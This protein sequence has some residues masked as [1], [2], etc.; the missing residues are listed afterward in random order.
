MNLTCLRSCTLALLLGAMTN[1]T[2]AQNVIYPGETLPGTALLAETDGTYTLSNDLLSVSFVKDGTSLKFGGCQALNLLSGSELF[3]LN[4]GDGTVVPASAMTLKAVSTETLTANPDAVKGSEKFPGQAIVAEFE[5]NGLNVN[6]RAV[7]RDGSHY[8]RT[9]MEISPVSSNVNMKSIVAM[10]YDVKNVEGRPAPQVVGNTRGAI[11]ASDM[12]FAG[13]ETPMG[14]NS[15]LS[16]SSG[17]ESFTPTSWTPESFSWT[18]GNETPAAILELKTIAGNQ[19]LT[20]DNIVGTR[21]YLTFRQ[22][23][24]QTVTFQYASG[25]HRLNIVGVD[26]CDPQTGEVIAS[27]YHAGFTGGQK[28]DNVYTLNLPRA[29]SFIVRYFIETLS[30]TITSSGN[31]TYSGKIAIPEVVFGKDPAAEKPAAVRRVLS[32][33]E[34][35]V[36]EEGETETD[37]WTGSSWTKT[38]VE[39]VPARIKE[40][41][42]AQEN[43]RQMERKISFREPATLTVEF[44]YTSGNHRLDI[45]GVDLIDGDGNVVVNDY[46]NGYSGHN[47]ENNVYKFDVPFAGDFSIRYFA[48]NADNALSTNGNINLSYNKTYVIYLPV[49]EAQTI[50]GLWSRPVTLEAGKTWTVSAVAGL[51]APD[52]A[53]RSVAAY[54]D[55]ERAVAW[56]PFPIYNSWFELNINRKD[57]PTYNS[58]MKVSD[59]V[60]VVNQ[61]EKKLYQA[62]GANIGAFVWDDGW[63]EWGSWEFNKNFP[64]GFTEINEVATSMNTGIGT[65]L[66]PVGGYGTSG[67]SRR[68]YWNGKGGMQLSNP[69][70][71]DVFLNACSRMIRD[72][73]F[74]FFKFDGISGLFAAYGPDPNNEEGAEGIIDIEQRLREIKPDIFLNTT[75]GTW[76]SPFWYTVSDCTW[77][78]ENDYGKAGN[79]SIDREQWITYRD[80]LVYQNY[81]TG[82]PLCPIN[83]IM[84]HGLIL[85]S[86]ENP[87]NYSQDYQ[88]VLR[89]MRCAFASGSSMVELYTDYALMNKISGDGKKGKLWEDMAECIFWQQN[90]ADVLPDAHWVG[91]N[92]WTG[93]KHE[94]YGW[95]SWNGVKSTLALRNGDNNAQTFTTTLREALDIPAHV[96]GSIRLKSSFKVQDALEGMPELDTPID[97]DRELTLVLPA[98]S[99][100]CFDGIDADHEWPV[101]PDPVLP[102]EEDPNPDSSIG[103]VNAD[104]ANSTLYDLQGR[105]V[106]T[107]ALPGLYIRD[108]RVIKL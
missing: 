94:V 21:G 14:K 105:R 63:D 61:W 11:I 78:Q 85:T 6:W 75:V 98:S 79:N 82:S 47:K 22:A 87:C 106:N 59:C 3:V 39:N 16:E 45:C 33:A 42:V 48:Y 8:F 101:Y 83:S 26:V 60:R 52:Q 20:A 69:A 64:N 9:E 86:H 100:Y 28:Q 5:G 72:Y 37:S 91:G 107:P 25:T 19:S 99:V 77:R 4:L 103:E 1:L 66:G 10:L 71:Y 89:E 68:A 35:T 96:K 41:G 56:R 88:A 90:N 49:P 7:L 29:G 50:Q 70:Y 81:V 108:G 32:A 2:D 36:L 76:A 44:V 23:G 54:V 84:T 53:R 93:S 80:R 104:N 27:D 43:V 17:L 34:N 55:R 18:P 95:A 24:E 31:I 67:N 58:H 97:I 38:G 73:D 74:R 15:V 51:I 40:L 30:E 13:L 62:Y 12:L 46:H 57:D 65:W 92:P 102:G